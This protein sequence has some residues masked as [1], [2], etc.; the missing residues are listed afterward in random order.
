MLSLKENKM[1]LSPYLI[2]IGILLLSFPAYANDALG[3]L[4]ARSV[5]AFMWGT[6][7]VLIVELGYCIYRFKNTSFL[8][9]ILFVIT[10][11][12]VTTIMGF[13]VIMLIPDYEVFF[14]VKGALLR[15]LI[16]YI[17]TVPVEA[18]ILK[19]FLRTTEQLNYLNAF[20]KSWSNNLTTNY[21]KS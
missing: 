6:I 1:M 2:I 4:L 20:I 10:A 16:F 18:L 5:E 12:V 17:C 21:Y 3:V 14:T 8:R 7:W 13:W 11:N 19:W 9:N 15:F